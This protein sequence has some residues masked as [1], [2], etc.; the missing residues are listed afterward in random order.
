MT[1]KQGHV[2]RYRLM[3]VMALES[4]ARVKVAEVDHSRP[5]PLGKQFIVS[6]CDLSPQP[7]AY[8]HG[9]IPA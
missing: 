8:F 7:M 6:A 1:A 3:R 4:G 9:E 2:Y 5:W